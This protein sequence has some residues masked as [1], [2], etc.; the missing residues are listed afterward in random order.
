MNY[1]RIYDQ[2]IF[3]AKSENRKKKCGVYYE[4]H[5]IT[6]KCL[7]GTNNKM[8]LVLLT[9]KEHFICHKLLVE[10]YPTNILLMKALFMMTRVRKTDRNYRV[11][12]REYDRMK[13]AHSKIISVMRS[14]CKHSEETKNKYFKNRQGKN[15]SNFGNVGSKNSN[16]GHIMP[17]H[18]KESLS[19]IHKG[20]VIS[21][22]TKNKLSIAHK[23]K[24]HS[25]ETR[26]KMQNWH[27]EHP[28]IQ[29]EKSKRSKRALGDKNKMFGKHHSI[30]TKMKISAANK[31]KIIIVSDSTK[32]KLSE[33]LKLRPELTCPICGFKNN[34]H[35]NMKRY[36]FENCR[37]N[38]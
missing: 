11:S 29:E 17:D 14:G 4:N 5:H 21:E 32:V 10:I 22:E 28:M 9:A 36:H 31:G 13:I 38:F 16:F 8:N 15:N 25:E 12:S 3:R 19:K 26:K 35:G 6:P 27:K 24:M 33:L 23:G 20:K 37:R 30:E 7:G 18:V 2:I 34:N 1:Q